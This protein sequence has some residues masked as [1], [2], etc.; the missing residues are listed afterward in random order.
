[1]SEKIK[2]LKAAEFDSFIAQG[3]VIVDFW[4]V[5]CGPCRMQGKILDQCAD[6]LAAAGITLA[7]VNVDEE[8]AL[9]A[10]FGVSSIPTLIAFENGQAK[11]TLV[12]IQQADTLKKVF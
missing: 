6:D 2:E 8:S 7:K 1:M 4:A 12:G 5:W 3:R 9:A 10:R 11:K